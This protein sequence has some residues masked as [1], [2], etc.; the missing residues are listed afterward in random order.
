MT[1][2]EDAPARI[3]ISVSFSMTSR[4]ND[5]VSETVVVVFEVRQDHR[6]EIDLIHGGS[7]IN[8]STYLLAPGE[9]K[10]ISVNATNTGNLVDDLSLFVEANLLLSGSDSS[11]DWGANGSSSTGVAV[12]ETEVLPI[13]ASVPEDSWNGSIMRVD[14]IADARNEVVMEFHFFVEVSRVPGWGISSSMSDL[15][16]DATGSS[17]EIEILQEGNK[18]LLCFIELF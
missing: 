11:Q 10:I 4:G 8:G 14:V 13:S 12:N 5:S 18:H 7:P 17:V 2:P 3:P 9:S 16:I 6:W 1:L 15:E